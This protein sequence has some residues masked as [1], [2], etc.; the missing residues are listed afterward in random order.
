MNLYR[1]DRESAGYGE[2]ETMLVAAPDEPAARIAAGKFVRDGGNSF[3]FDFVDPDR[4]TAAHVGTAL[5]GSDAILM[6]GCAPA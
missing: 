3:A 5:D 1:L 6:V 2:I 4:T